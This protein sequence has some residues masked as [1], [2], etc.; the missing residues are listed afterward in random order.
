M[1]TA[2]VM[3]T[4]ATLVANIPAM[5]GF[6]PRESLVAVWLKDGSVMV[7]QRA[8][9]DEA[10]E[11]GPREYARDVLRNDP[12]AVVLVV[13][14]DFVDSDR[15]EAFWSYL[16]AD[17]EVRDVLQVSDGEW[18]S[19]MCHDPKCG[20]GGT[21]DPSLVAP[22][23]DRPI[24]H[25]RAALIIEVEPQGSEPMKPL[26]PH[27]IDGWR[28]KWITRG[29]DAFLNDGF[30]S[31]KQARGMSRALH[32]IRVRDSL[33]WHL[34]QLTPEETLRAYGLFAAACRVTHPDDAAPVA[35][36]AALA[37]WLSGDGA[38][39]NVAADV[40]RVADPNYSMLHLIHVALT[41]AM[42]PTSWRDA[43]RDLTFDDCRY[44][45]GQTQ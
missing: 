8:D 23:L 36:C 45:K 1:S 35:T 19:L 13:Y 26:K 39:A 21:V 33:L 16:Q 5:V 7:T 24:A 28:D 3:R 12:D 25:D 40:A 14:S 29:I 32:D 2:V 9:L 22:E 15:I 38:R 11:H 10:L 17:L 20:C 43:M 6:E 18:S 4:P 44:G 31:V 30:E 34:S 41:A 27:G 42:P 37:A